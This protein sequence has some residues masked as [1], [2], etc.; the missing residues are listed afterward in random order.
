M[1]RSR[2]KQSNISGEVAPGNIKS[3]LDPAIA[4]RIFLREGETRAIQKGK[5]LVIRKR[6]SEVMLDKEVDTAKE[7][8]I[9]RSLVLSECTVPKDNDLVRPRWHINCQWEN[10]LGDA[11]SHHYKQ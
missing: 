6:A 7:V 2:W 8:A 11:F 1:R 9:A 10:P 3:I 5:G 4:K